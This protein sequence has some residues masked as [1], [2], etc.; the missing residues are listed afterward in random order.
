MDL[1]CLH[2]KKESA[3]ALGGVSCVAFFITTEKQF[4]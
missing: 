1:L 3:H 2:L 4:Q